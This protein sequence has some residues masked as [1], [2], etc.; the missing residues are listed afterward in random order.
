MNDTKKDKSERKWAR[1]TLP[2]GRPRLLTEEDKKEIIN[3]YTPLKQGRGIKNQKVD[4]TK[5]SKNELAEKFN[6]DPCTILRALNKGKTSTQIK[7]DTII[8]KL[9]TEAVRKAMIDYKGGVC[10]H[11]GHGYNK[12]PQ[13]LD[14]HHVKKAE[15][16]I[17]FSRMLAGGQ[18]TKFFDEDSNVVLPPYILKELDKC[19]LV[20]SNCHREI[21][22]EQRKLELPPLFLKEYSITMRKGRPTKERAKQIRV[23]EKAML[24]ANC[25]N[26]TNETQTPLAQINEWVFFP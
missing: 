17:D 6:V 22:A 19:I 13:A 24:N 10:S 15:K 7:R 11:N 18:I 20:C 21:H 4:P 16:E 1:A 3:T 14:F 2:H 25:P 8:K 9:R 12:C 26:D 23:F 5:L